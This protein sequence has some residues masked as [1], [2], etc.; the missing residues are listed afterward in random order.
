VRFVSFVPDTLFVTREW[1]SCECES[2]SFSHSI[3]GGCVQ[4]KLEAVVIWANLVT[5]TVFVI[6][7]LKTVIFRA[8]HYFLLSLAGD[9]TQHHHSIFPLLHVAIQELKIDEHHQ[10][11]WLPMPTSNSFYCCNRKLDPCTS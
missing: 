4:S 11:V 8:G 6:R 2:G 9:I 10:L 1:W 7:S 5:M 3:I